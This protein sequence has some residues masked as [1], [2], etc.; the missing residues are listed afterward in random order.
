MQTKS[1]SR[2]LKCTLLACITASLASAC[3][4]TTGDGDDDDDFFDGGDSN[5]GTSGKT[6]STGGAGTSGTAGTSTGGGGTSAGTGATAGTSGSGGTGGTE[7]AYVPGLCDSDSDDE[8]GPTPTVLPPATLNEADEEP[9]GECRKCLKTECPTDWQICYGKEPTIACGWGDTED[10]DGQFDCVVNC[11]ADGAQ[12]PMGTAE[13]L[14]IDCTSECTNQCDDG[15]NLMVH[16]SD[17]LA[18]ANDADKCQAACF[19][20]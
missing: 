11:F 18:C 1:Y 12:D 4:V 8:L 17:L 19:P 15:G 3:V 7:P 20:F 9:E 5:S 6:S 10:A 16:T 14:F 2:L 13:E